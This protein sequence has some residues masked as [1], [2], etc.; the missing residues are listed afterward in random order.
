MAKAPGAVG[1]PAP[2]VFFRGS[3]GVRLTAQA[4][5]RDPGVTSRPD[6]EG[7]PWCSIN[8]WSALRRGRGG[9]PSPL[10][11]CGHSALCHWDDTDS[12]RLIDSV[13]DDVCGCSG[14]SSDAS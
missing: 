4:V 11:R 7:V 8:V 1:G 3:R 14:F 12:C 9:D 2:T 10:C 6:R 13:T 5:R